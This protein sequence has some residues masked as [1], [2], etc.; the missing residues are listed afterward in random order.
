MTVEIKEVRLSSVEIAELEKGAK[1]IG[2]VLKMLES[3][4]KSEMAAFVILIMV[5][6]N[7]A[8]EG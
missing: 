3:D 4:D 8:R 5:I 7:R 1:R 6:C 2:R